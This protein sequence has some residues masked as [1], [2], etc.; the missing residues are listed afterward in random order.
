MNRNEIKS[1]GEFIKR[2]RGEVI[3]HKQ[4]KNKDMVAVFFA[5]TYSESIPLKTQAKPPEAMIKNENR[6]TFKWLPG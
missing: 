2:K 3:Q 5:P 6:E 1:K 4:D